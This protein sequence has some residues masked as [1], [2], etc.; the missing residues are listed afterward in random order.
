MST[1][2]T[3]Q[4]INFAADDAQLDAL[5]A[6]DSDA[7]EVALAQL[8]SKDAQ[9]ATRLLALLEAMQLDL[10]GAAALQQKA[11]LQIGAWQ[12]IRHLGSGGMAD[13]FLVERHLEG[14]VQRAALKHLKLLDRTQSSQSVLQEHQLLAQLEHPHIARLIDVGADADGVA[15]LVMEFVNGL[16]ITDYANTR[17]LSLTARVGL[18]IQLL[19]A[20][21]YA[22]ARL[23][24][25][26]DIKPSN[27]L[28]DE[29]GNVRLLDFGIA[30]RVD[31][32]N[33]S[34]GTS[35]LQGFRACTPAYAAPEQLN[36][37]AISSM[38]DVYGVG[39]LA[40]ELLT[41]T[42]VVQGTLADRLR[43]ASLQQPPDFASTRVKDRAVATELK[44][45]LDWI[46]HR[47]L[48]PSPHLRYPSCMAFAADLKAHV[49]GDTVQ[50]VPASWRYYLGS[51]VYR[52]RYLLVSVA[53]SIAALSV[54]LAIALGQA[55]RARL[56]LANTHSALQL[57]KGV[58][59]RAVP[60]DAKVEVT[61]S[62]LLA[63]GESAVAKLHGNAPL[64]AQMYAVLADSY[65]AQLRFADAVRMRQAQLKKM[66]ESDSAATS[67]IQAQIALAQAASL[68]DQDRL[69]Q[70]AAEA[71]LRLIAEQS[72][73]MPVQKAQATQELAG[74]HLRQGNLIEA[75]S[76]MDAALASVPEALIDPS[77][78]HA[79][80]LGDLS[81]WA[82]MKGDANE[83]V[84]YA[85]R[86]YQHA[87]THAEG[88]ASDRA[89]IR[90][91]LVTALSNARSN[92][93]AALVVE[94]SIAATASELGQQNP[95]YWVLRFKQANIS[96]RT[97]L[98]LAKQQFFAAFADKN[99]WQYADADQL[100]IAHADYA[101]SLIKQGEFE[102]ASIQAAQMTSAKIA[103]AS[104]V[105]KARLRYAWIF[106]AVLQDD[107]TSADQHYVQA[108]TAIVEVFG[109]QHPAYA[110]VLHAQ[111]QILI[112]KARF[113]EAASALGQ[114]E[115]FAS[116]EN[117]ARLVFIR[118]LCLRSMKDI[119]SLVIY[120]QALKNSNAEQ[121][122]K[123]QRIWMSGMSLPELQR[124][125]SAD[126]VWLL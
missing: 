7:R 88:S 79:S 43:F 116:E 35:T 87:N 115:A 33:S 23:V 65:S 83:A 92:G 62:Q 84:E 76:L 70:P 72:N 56:E 13:V 30:K 77:L 44:R 1:E 102:L 54:G 112:A 42:L 68:S 50:A 12:I 113:A 97:D 64:Q 114:A 71:A 4:S 17:Q 58:F 32:K 101:D 29:F 93:R 119:Q 123:M 47:A 75:K 14:A 124:Q 8:K 120:Q 66:Y 63:E 111:A 110:R 80:V 25:H 67:R 121:N 126:N 96:S 36:A 5:L 117:A 39:A 11:P 28:V 15:Y 38:S 108:Q 122:Q 46:L 85:E 24:V 51:Y 86:A 19:D 99:A 20:L 21:S 2:H 9:Q 48:A 105:A 45:G 89:L 40:Y 125:K 57:I 10:P 74:F 118:A 106:L 78:T 55:K 27:V 59:L 34:L 81:V 73:A 3:L 22:H 109:N 91:Q 103:S 16:S 61:A 52:H 53:A 98:I 60:A 41:G 6:L 104:A 37:E 107:L 94:E 69:V 49:S 100:A 26:L 31:A 82:G 18:L 90:V 95:Y